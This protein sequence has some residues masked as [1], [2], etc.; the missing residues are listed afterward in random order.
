MTRRLSRSPWIL[1]ALALAGRLPIAAAN[2]SNTAA[3]RWTSIG[4][5]VSSVAALAVSPLGVAYASTLERGAFPS[6]DGG[7]R[8]SP[9]TTPAYFPIRELAIDPS[10]PRR[11]YARGYQGG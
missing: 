5:D 8:W 1:L 6:P 10:D 3:D 11:V 7:S 2:A 4:P 9:P